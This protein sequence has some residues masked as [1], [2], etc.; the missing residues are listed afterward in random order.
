MK[1][2]FHGKE[3]REDMEGAVKKTEA[4]R[5]PLVEAVRAALVPVTH[6]LRIEAP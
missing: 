1:Q 3:G 5:A 2:I 6:V 4:E